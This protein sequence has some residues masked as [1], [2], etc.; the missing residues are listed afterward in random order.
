[1]SH[2]ATLEPKFQERRKNQESSK[3]RNLNLK[4]FYISNRKCP[5]GKK[6]IKVQIFQ[7]QQIR[8][9]QKFYFHMYN[10]NK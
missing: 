9:Y 4:K 6:E 7:N 3:G 5:K 2:E 1:M 10:R 8:K